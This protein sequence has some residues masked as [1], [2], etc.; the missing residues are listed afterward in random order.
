MKVV[1]DYDPNTGN[2]VCKDGTTWN[3]QNLKY[4]EYI[5]YDII[6]QM[7][8]NGYTAEQLIELKRAGVI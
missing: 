2:V 1:I 4:E 8:K 5:D 7:I 3:I 6:N